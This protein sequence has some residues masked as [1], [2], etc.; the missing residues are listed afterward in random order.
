MRSYKLFFAAETEDVLIRHRKNPSFT[1]VEVR[2]NRVMRCSDWM[3]KRTDELDLLAGAGDKE[4]VSKEASKE[5][6]PMTTDA[7]EQAKVVEETKEEGKKE[8]EDVEMKE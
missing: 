7:T 6:S 3:D 4:E 2:D 1:P 8:G 5:A